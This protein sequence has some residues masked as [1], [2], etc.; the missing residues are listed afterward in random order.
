MFDIIDPKSE[1]R[2]PLLNLNIYVPRDEQFGQLKMADFLTYAFKGVVRV[3]LPVLQAIAGATPIEFNSFEDVLK[4]Y[5]GGLPVPPNP[6]LEELRQLVPFE[7]IRELRRVEGG[8]GLL[9]LPM[10]HVI[11]GNNPDNRL[12][13]LDRTS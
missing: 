4:L 11:Q 5:E 7:M 10:P 6:L 9:K 12:T 1:S 2:L 3:V 13:G 8:R